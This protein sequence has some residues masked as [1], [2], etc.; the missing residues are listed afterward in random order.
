MSA[1]SETS[2]KA[3]SGAAGGPPLLE[4][5]GISK[6]FYGVRV[7]DKVD[8]DCK[9]GEVHAIVGENGAGKSTLMKILVGAYTPTEGEVRIEGEPVSFSHPL[10]GQHA[11][12]SIIYQ[13]FNLLPDRSVAENI[14]LG[15]EPKRG[16]LVDRRQMEERSAEILEQLAPDD[17]ISPRAQVGLLS[18]DRQQTV[19]I[20]K[21]LSLDSKIVVM[22]EPTAALAAHEVE[23]LFEQIERLKERGI[24]V[25]YI[26]HRLKEIFEIAERVTVLKDGERVDTKRP[27]EVTSPDLVRMMVG[28]ELDQYFPQRADAG[29]RGPV[30]LRLRGAANYLLSNIDLDVHGG[31]ILGLAGLQ[32]SGRTELARAIFGADPFDTGKLELDGK[33]REIRSPREAVAAG[34]GFVTE[35]RKSEGLALMQSVRDNVA[36]AWRGLRRSLR[37]QHEL[38][39]GELTKAVELRARGLGQEVRFLSGGNQ[40]KVV[41]AK[42]LATEPQ[43]VIFDE[44]TRGIDVGAKAGIHDLIRGLADEG[45]AVIMISSELPEVIGMSDRIIV[46]RHGSIAG[47]LAAGPTEAEIMFLATGERDI[48]VDQPAATA[49]GGERQQQEEEEEGS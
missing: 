43:L 36:L 22:D 35:D 44:P 38:E 41:L 11:G 21:A 3:P 28:R 37:K 46:M 18:V 9:A 2:E 49:A 30:K 6:E 47:E 48:D 27:S 19:E 13:E 12:V 25:V 39:I 20:A 34:I 23:R 16:L 33:E 5:R 14:F 8:L 17:P 24:G 29:S 15:R 45:V 10:E 1:E 42:W 40:Q 7:L 26:S 32:G 31:E 4:M